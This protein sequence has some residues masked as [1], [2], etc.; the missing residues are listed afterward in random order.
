MVISKSDFDLLQILLNDL[1]IWQPSPTISSAAAEIVNSI[2]A[3]GPEASFAS[4]HMARSNFTANESRYGDA[5]TDS[6]I[7]DE[8]VDGERFQ[9]RHPLSS[10]GRYDNSASF[11]QMTAFSAAVSI[12]SGM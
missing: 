10:D 11:G 7:E 9:T 8:K 4:F 12:G 5:I 1:A 2:G 6:D 3:L